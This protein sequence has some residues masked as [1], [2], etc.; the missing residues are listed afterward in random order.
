[1]N[2]ALSI[3]KKEVVTTFRNK[4]ALAFMALFPLTFMLMLGFTF[5][6]ES[7]ATV[8][9]AICDE[10]EGEVS[11]AFVNTINGTDLPP[12]NRTNWIFRVRTVELRVEGKWLVGNGTVNA[13]I[14]IPQGFTHNITRGLQSYV[15]V[16]FDKANPSQA[17]IAESSIRGFIQS[18]T[19]AVAEEKIK[20]VQPFLQDASKSA[21]VSVETMVMYMQALGEPI[22]VQQDFVSRRAFRYVD[23]LVP[24]MIGVAVLWVGLT[25]S[26]IT[27]AE[28]KDSGTLKRILL[29]PTGPW[30]VL[31]GKTIGCLI[32][33]LLSSAIAVIGG[34][35]IFK[36]T[37]SGDIPLALLVLILGALS[38]I[39]LGLIFSSLAENRTAASNMAVIFS[40]PAQFLTGLFFP[41]TMMPDFMQ[42]LSKVFPFTYCVDSLRD[43]LIYQAPWSKVAPNLLILT[44]YS[45]ALYV[46]GAIVYKKVAG[47]YAL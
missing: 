27:I 24:G 47:G 43:I 37:F 10:D 36:V 13:Y 5:G 38:S 8:S 3:A 21:G 28:E 23:W 40:L 39:G 22:V 45:L 46:V 18:F 4:Q 44:A 31:A 20:F 11:R 35:L 12:A 29:T 30:P 25:T 14:L 17:Q 6:R 41:L 42:I 15:N 32:N 26:A 1:M 7:I 33:I 34:M 16:T 9:L 19:R 2:K